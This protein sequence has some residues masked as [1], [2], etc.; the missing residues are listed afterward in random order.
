MSNERSNVAA[1]C[2]SLALVI[3]CSC[4]NDGVLLEE[5]H[6][7][8]QIDGGHRTQIDGGHDSSNLNTSQEYDASHV[9]RSRDA[10]PED[11]NSN[12]FTEPNGKIYP[13]N[14]FDY[15]GSFRLP[16]EH[17][18]S[19]QWEYGGLGLAYRPDG[20]PSS[21]DAFPGSLF[22][23]GKLAENN[24]KN[25]V[26]EFSIPQ[27]IIS[28][29]LDNLNTAKTLQPFNDITGGYFDSTL[30]GHQLLET[31][32]LCYLD[33]QGPQTA[34]KLYWSFWS[35][36][37]VG[38]EDLPSQGYSDIDI[39]QPNAQGVW[40]LSG[41]HSKYA[42][43]YL[44]DIPSYWSNK[45]I[46]GNRL[47]V[48]VVREGGKYSRGPAMFTIAPYNYSS[49]NPPQDGKL[50]T[51][52]LIFYNT[53][54]DNY[55]DYV[56]NDNWEGGAWITTT[57][58]QA[59]VFVGSKCGGPSCYGTGEHC[60]DSC[61]SYKGYHCYPRIPQI[62]FYDVSEL[63]AVAAGIK[64]PWDPQPYATLDLREIIPFYHT[65]SITS[66]IAYDRN[67]HLLYLIQRGIDAEKPVIHTIRVGE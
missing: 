31:T 40:K 14:D 30:A 20:D 28:A 10:N 27:P 35:S 39:A 2:L 23:V 49:S 17:S 21:N 7:R 65:C 46:D 29:N 47:A 5:D 36:Y 56:E 43:G 15:V 32:G 55:P 19:Y 33:A 48:G 57:N 62:V 3:V 50:P 38:D 53:D 44:F 51:T 54:H 63:E 59:V 18:N 52:P 34:S 61:N 64:E 67:N 4:S 60:G 9:D 11:D 8:T 42:S 22:S 1:L 6:I 24:V 13:Q 25:F 45:H 37:N 12:N 16:N 58:K 41:Y 66:G 26:S